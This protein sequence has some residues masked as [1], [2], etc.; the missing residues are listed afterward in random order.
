MSSGNNNKSRLTAINSVSSSNSDYQCLS[1][2]SLYRMGI[3]C[4][5][6]PCTTLTHHLPSTRSSTSSNHSWRRKWRRGWA[7]IAYHV[8]YFIFNYNLFTRVASVT[9]FLSVECTEV[10]VS[11]N[12][13]WHYLR[14]ITNQGTAC[15]KDYSDVLIN[16]VCYCC[17]RNLS[18]L[19]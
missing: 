16:N 17:R 2:C 10:Y 19:N 9:G 6:K 8:V 11:W 13:H 7:T 18:L 5:L 4:V 14:E 3:P 1:L 15:N 12:Y